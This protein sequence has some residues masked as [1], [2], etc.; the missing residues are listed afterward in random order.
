MEQ[1]ARE[2]A[3]AYELKIR[4]D[5]VL[6][7]L[8]LY[9]ETTNHLE[10]ARLD[11]KEKVKEFKR[12]SDA[13]ANEYPTIDWQTQIWHNSACGS[14]ATSSDGDNSLIFASSSRRDLQVK[15]KLRCGD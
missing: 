12:L 13:W 10:Q 2:L 8:L 7:A 9:D 14:Q 3:L 4:A 1:K 5:K 11:A 15:V 6:E